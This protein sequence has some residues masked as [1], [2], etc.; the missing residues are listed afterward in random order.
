MLLSKEI[1]AI[2]V[3][4]RNESKAR[5]YVRPLIPEVVDDDTFWGMLVEM[6]EIVLH[7]RGYVVVKRDILELSK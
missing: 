1:S 2:A 7:R 3:D 6:F 4:L 5:L